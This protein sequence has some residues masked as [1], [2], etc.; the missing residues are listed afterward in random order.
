[1][2]HCMQTTLA[3]TFYDRAFKKHI[4]I[5]GLFISLKLP[6]IFPFSDLHFSSQTSEELID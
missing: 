1:M 2:L 3:L 4:S 5:V 6:L